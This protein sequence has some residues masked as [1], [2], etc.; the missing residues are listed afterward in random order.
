[1]ST[2]THVAATSVEKLDWAD[3]EA[4]VTEVGYALA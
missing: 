1:M 3:I 2:G 4:V